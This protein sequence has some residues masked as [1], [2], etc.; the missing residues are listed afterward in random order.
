MSLVPRRPCGDCVV[1]RGLFEP[2]KA[3]LMLAYLVIREDAKWTDVFR[4]VPGRTVTIGRAA[5]NQIVVKDER[6]SRNHAEVFMTNGRWTLRDLG[7]RNGTLVGKHRVVGD[8][9]LSPGE[10]VWI[11]KCQLAFVHDLSKAFADGKGIADD[12]ADQDGAA[13]IA[14]PL[15]V[16]D[17]RRAGRLGRARRSRRCRAGSVARPDDDHAPAR[18]DAVP[19][20]ARRRRDHSARVMPR[21]GYVRWSLNWPSSRTLPRWPAGL[22]G[23]VRGH[24]GG[25]RRRAAVRRAT[26]RNR[27]RHGTSESSRGARTSNLATTAFRN[28][29][30]T[31]CCAKGRPCSPAT[32]WRQ[33]AR[34]AG[35][36]GRDPRDQRDLRT[37]S[38]AGKRLW[39]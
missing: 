17:Q 14:A 29:S 21:R 4:L 23:P 1:G 10:I 28:S 35:Q 38:P 19:Q 8:Y 11:A 24:Q 20:A 18:A 36:Q 25:R 16:A 5:T 12:D 9:T 32:W 2:P 39:A 6:C 7:S 26:R 22:G 34:Y 37:D 27:S 3:Q 30:P 33:H 31:R 13:T 15:A